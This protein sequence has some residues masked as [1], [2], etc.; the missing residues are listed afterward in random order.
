MARIDDLVAQVPDKVLRQKLQ[1]AFADMK[2]RQ[3]FGLVYEEHVPESTALL[4]L[5]V[6]VGATVQRRTDSSGSLFQ[7]KSMT[8][9]TA[10]VEPED[11]GELQSIPLKELLVVKR[12]GDPIFPA[13][14][15]L[16]SIQRGKDDKPYHAVI[17]G[18]NFHALQLLVYL[19]EG[20]VDCIYIDPP[21]NTGAR[22][23]K[24]N[25][26][27][28]DKTD[29]WRH[30]KWLSFMEKRLKL[31]K[32]LLRND[33]VLVVTI[34]EHEVHHLGMLLEK[35]FPNYLRYTVTAVINPK[36]TFKQ[37][38][39]RV[40][41]QIFFVVPDLDRDVIAP[42]LASQGE[43]DSED[44]VAHGLIRHLA[45][46]AKIEPE[47]FTLQISDPDQQALYEEALSTD[48]S[49]D[50]REAAL[51]EIEDSNNDDASDYE[52]WFLRRRG[53][54][55]SY[56]HQR[57]RSFYAIH[58]DVES[59][60]VIG[61]GPEL[62]KEEAYKVTKAKGILSVYPID[63]EGHERVWRYSRPT[64]QKY[65]DA[66][67]IVVGRLNRKTNTWTLN[68]R[69]LK[70]DVRRHKTVWWETR[71]DAGVHGTNIVNNLL[72]KRGLFP[73]PKSVYA[74]QDALAAVVRN[75]PDALILDFFAGSGTT[76]HAT[77]LLN[78][79]DG[80][81]R[82][83]ILV[84]NNEV[85]E[86][87]ASQLNKQGF[88]R[89][90]AHFEAQGIFSLVTRPR[91]EAVVTGCRP[92][93]TQVPKVHVN[94][95]PFKDGF[96]ENV[97]FFAVDY[98]DADE[99]EMQTQFAA[100]LPSLW[101]AAGGVGSRGHATDD[102]EM[103]LPPSGHFAVLLREERFR[104]FSRELE[105]RKDIRLVYLVTDS[106]NAFAEMRA[107]LPPHVSASMLYRDYLRNFRINTR[108]NV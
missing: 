4:G 42:R 38:F 27:Y 93:G 79:E 41:E 59:K 102:H 90:D 60:Q 73:F 67:E 101:L 100:I 50:E 83:S 44:T 30:S 75:R 66:G 92:D 17:N 103:F 95:R 25:N 34:D 24:Y 31:A 80:G 65:I 29:S 76:F 3:R 106:E 69:K 89:G 57:Y 52:D 56:R 28:V 46:L 62:G 21:Y 2:K 74:V 105:K 104:K 35:I 55:S 107:S 108:H 48:D 13:L 99:V 16:G 49:E 8:T 98:L 33:G 68:H 14:T 63:N 72:G 19:Y 32:R 64:M 15:S 36:G 81:S 7:V 82:R 51:S 58:I 88:Y 47:L 77:C 23:W 84:T 10:R 97:E 71:H 20:Q 45:S 86:K 22:D 18:E 6:H 12:F 26:S 61:I 85:G 5:P 40:D 11:G 1:A 70:K 43:N 87:Q 91:C 96:E 53:Q 78:A 9:R 37:N 54:E 94:K 39:G